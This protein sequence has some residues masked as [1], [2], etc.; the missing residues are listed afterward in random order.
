MNGPDRDFRETI[1]SYAEQLRGSDE[2][3]ALE[4]ALEQIENEILRDLYS[5]DRLTRDELSEADAWE[6]LAAI[7]S[8]ASVASG[9]VARYYG[10]ASPWPRSVSGWSKKA[11]ARLRSIANTLKSALQQVA[12]ALQA[13]GFTIGVSFPWGIS[14]G[15]SF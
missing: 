7:E 5:D 10:P 3:Q 8:W 11:A 13:V 15:V 4:D 12:N 1:G 2:E 14:I 6:Q 9:T